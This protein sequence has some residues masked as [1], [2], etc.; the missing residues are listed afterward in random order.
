MFSKKVAIDLGTTNCL[1]S[2]EDQ[3]I[4]LNEP[5]VVAV[6]VDD[7]QVVA[8]GG[9]AKEMLGRTPVGIMASCPLRHGVIADYVTTEA[10]LKYFV[11]KALGRTRFVKPDLMIS[12]PSGVSSVESRAVLD[13]AYSAG[14]RHAFLIPE[15]LAAALGA[16]IPVSEA[17]GSIIV[18]LGGGTTEVAVISLG[19]IVVSES[20]RVAGTNLD[21]SITTFLR[22]RYNLMIGERTAELLKIKIGSAIDPEPDLSAEVKGRD[23]IS[24]L[25]R[26]VEVTTSEVYQAFRDPLS[27]IISGVK[28]V[29]ERT[30]PELASDVIDKGMVLSGG[31]AQLKGLDKLL[32]RELGVPCHIAEEPLLCVVKGAALAINNMAIV[33]RNLTTR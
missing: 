17:S 29:L 18:N 30:P 23:S 8:V 7:N 12:V 31:T 25:P 19:G 3:G 5:T 4:I 21:E 14:A 2:V 15:P 20:V 24:G 11:G 6:T 13:A 26:T 1:V 27:Q 22:R 9:E 32:T 16:R 28:T 10:M 33:K